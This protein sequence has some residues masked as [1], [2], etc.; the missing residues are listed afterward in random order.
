[1]LIYGASDAVSGSLGRFASKISSYE[2]I[3]QSV[4]LHLRRYLR[5]RR[6]HSL[7]LLFRGY[8]ELA[9]ADMPAVKQEQTKE[10]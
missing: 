7:G 9:L 8:D 4:H 6:S 10:P 2:R 1:M 5:P 3:T